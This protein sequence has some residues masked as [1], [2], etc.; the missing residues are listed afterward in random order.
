[1]A[2]TSSLARSVMSPQVGHPRRPECDVS[3]TIH[4][5][6]QLE[7]QY[8]CIVKLGETAVMWYM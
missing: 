6:S 8:F 4:S 1:M 7:T 3:K 5:L 2:F